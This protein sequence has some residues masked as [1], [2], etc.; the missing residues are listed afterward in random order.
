MIAMIAPG[1]LSGQKEVLAQCTL[2]RRHKTQLAVDCRLDWKRHDVQ[3]GVL[4][5]GIVVSL[6]AQN[7]PCRKLDML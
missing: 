3:S 6:R 7:L 2:E 5:A 1:R 4:L